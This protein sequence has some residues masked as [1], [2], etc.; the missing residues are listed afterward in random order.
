MRL[1]EGAKQ[2][3]SQGA[4]EEKKRQID[5]DEVRQKEESSKLQDSAN[6]EVKATGEWT[7][8]TACVSVDTS[9]SSRTKKKRWA[10]VESTDASQV[11]L[12]ADSLIV[13]TPRLAKQR[14]IK[15]NHEMHLKQRRKKRK[16]E[17]DAVSDANTEANV[18]TTE[19]Q[20]MV[21]E[22]VDTESTIPVP[23]STKEDIEP[24]QGSSAEPTQTPKRGRKPSLN[25]TNKKRGKASL[26]QIPGKPI[27]VHK[28]P[29]PKPGMK[30]A[31]EVIEAVVRAAGCEQAE[32]EEREREERE[33]NEKDT[34][35][36]EESCVVVPGGQY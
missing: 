30:D 9:K 21:E 13:T 18:E 32:K 6:V 8:D 28:K 35:E 3:V 34:K 11:A 23:I 17:T 36:K 16:E 12:E 33:G 20:E 1:E 22:K 25:Q 24:L 4:T 29:G 7:Q 10:M 27:K 15:N 26:E 5:G 19:Q 2:E 14:A 31:M